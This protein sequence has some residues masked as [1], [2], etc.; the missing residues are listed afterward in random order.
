MLFN[1]EM[2]A[3]IITFQAAHATMDAITGASN[4]PKSPNVSAASPNLNAATHA[5]TSYVP[6]RSSVKSTTRIAWTMLVELSMLVKVEF[7]L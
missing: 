3:L 1:F 5:L 4:V 6:T 7:Y 2:A